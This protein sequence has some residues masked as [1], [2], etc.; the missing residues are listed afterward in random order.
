MTVNSPALP[1]LPRKPQPPKKNGRPTAYKAAYAKQAYRLCLLGAT[2]S[3]L[4]KFFEVSV[5]TIDTWKKEHPRFLGSMQ[6]GKE[7]ADANVAH[8][9]YK[10]ALGYS[11]EAVKILTVAN[12]NNQGSTVET[13]PY[14]EHYPP[15]TAAAS[16]WLRN[17]QPKR[18][19]D[20]VEVEHSADESLTG[21]LARVRS[22]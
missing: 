8:S 2:D 22:K 16:L 19:R 13:V 14:T 20:K 12:G 1:T 10:R 17:R 3:D 21:L 7:T 9:L 15:D 4:A 18:W 6:D 11:H 5:P